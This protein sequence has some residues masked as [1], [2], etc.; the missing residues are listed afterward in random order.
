MTCPSS[1]NQW[2]GSWDFNPGVFDA[3]EHT[4]N[5]L[6]VVLHLRIYI[7]VSIPYIMLSIYWHLNFQISFSLSLSLPSLSSSSLPLL[8][9]DEACW[10]LRVLS[11]WAELCT[12]G[13]LTA[14]VGLKWTETLTV[15]Q[16]R[17]V[18]ISP[19]LFPSFTSLGKSCGFSEPCLPCL[20]CVWCQQELVVC[21]ITRAL[22]RI[23]G[24]VRCES[25]LW[26]KCHGHSVIAP[27]AASPLRWGFL[28]QET[29]K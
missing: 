6:Y 13:P 5:I 7:C 16:R 21:V 24:N 3:T 23:K 2:V 28:L 8:T 26:A 20:I 25:L 22:M 15:M 4:W 18:G 12:S 11:G 29:G 27:W 10:S 9:V 19:L 14:H 1:L 17:W